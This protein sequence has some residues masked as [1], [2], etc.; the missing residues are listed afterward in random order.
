MIEWDCG[1]NIDWKSPEI[2]KFQS[3]MRIRR[4]RLRIALGALLFPGTYDFPI[5]IPFCLVSV[6][7]TDSSLFHNSGDCRRGTLDLFL[8]G[9]MIQVFFRAWK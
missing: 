5:L 4:S 3:H 7:V 9:Q 1:R 6:W 2:R 8:K